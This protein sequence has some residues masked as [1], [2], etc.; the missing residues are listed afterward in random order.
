MIEK[1]SQLEKLKNTIEISGGGKRVDLLLKNARVINTFS[2]DIHRTHV[3]VH[4]GRVVGFGDYKAAQVMDLK[5]AY[6][7]PGFID[8]HV[9]IESSM[10]KIP[11]FARVVL[12]HGTTSAVIDPHEIANVLGLDGIKYMLA[13]S[14]D[15][16]LS[17]YVML[18][19]C[20]PATHL[21]T[22]GA[23]LTAHDLGLLLNDERVLGIGEMMDYPGVIGRNEEVM[24]KIAIAKNKVI[25]GHAPMLKGKQLYS[26]VSAGIRSDHECTDVAEAREKLRAGMYIMIREGTAAK[27]LKNLLPLVN[28]ENS[29]KFIFVTD[30]R[31]LEDVFR[32]GHIDY[33]VRTAIQ[34]GVDPIRAI[35]MATINTAEYF[36]IK[37]LGAIAPGYAADLV[38]FEDLKKLKI[39]KV[40]KSGKLVAKA[41]EIEPGVIHEYKGK[42]RGTINVKW[43]EHEDFALKA[44][45]KYARVMNV[46]PDQI[47]TKA[48]IEKV[49]EDG[50][51]VSSDTENDILKIAVIERHMA[52]GRVALA[53]VKGFGLKKGA[54]ASSVSHDSHNIVVV[55]TH[56]GD[57][58]TAAVQVVKMQG[59]IVAALNGQVLEALP[60]PVAGLMSDRSA[61]FVREKQARL[62]E[63][64]KMLG[65]KLSDPFMAM[66][67]LTL[68]P[69]P[70]IRITDRGLIDAVKFK[71]TPLFCGPK[72]K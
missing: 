59:G 71:V 39:S 5:G 54:I 38:V 53:L 46:I 55:G 45:G 41:G 13:S 28:S 67:F 25:D 2:G 34:L 37:N 26:Y 8:G 24:R 4:R 27:N 65:S 20:V 6:V 3:A 69:I 17:V 30:D 47:V 18:P 52:S 60:L 40:F 21:E 62:N 48:T 49:K 32:Q 10:V 11:E 16:P 36:G 68:P 70:E 57:M 72:G 15:S 9:H 29:R 56:D 1:D 42:T 19:S 66:S 63:I 61:E 22:A 33:L 12:P 35:Q 50:G 43:I 7:S 64:A 31:H 44:Q 14:E 58:Y 23:E 51:Y